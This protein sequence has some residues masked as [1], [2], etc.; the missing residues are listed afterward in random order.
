MKTPRILGHF[1]WWGA[2][3]WGGIHGPHI[4]LACVK[5]ALDSQKKS[6]PDQHCT[7]PCGCGLRL[8]EALKVLCGCFIALGDFLYN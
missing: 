3:Y 8:N 7:R 6:F 5:L 1:T 2:Q 4:T